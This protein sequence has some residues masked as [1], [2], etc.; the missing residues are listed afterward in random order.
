MF[1]CLRGAQPPPP[2]PFPFPPFA[3]SLRFFDGRTLPGY[4]SSGTRT[5]SSWVFRHRHEA[6]RFLNE[7]WE[8]LEKFGLCL[9]PEKTRLIEFGRLAA[10]RRWE[11]GYGRREF[12]DFLGFTHRWVRKHGK[13]G[14]IVRRTT[15]KKRL[16]AK[17]KEVG[18]TLRKHCHAPLGRQVVWLGWVVRGYFTYYAVPGNHGESGGVPRA[19]GPQL[20]E[21]IARPRSERSDEL[22]TLPTADGVLRSASQI[23]ASLSE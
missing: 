20:A 6:E 11:R 12:F 3:F 14:F 5:T 19:G 22:G 15:V 16:R 8:R 2:P 1:G 18:E 17:L 13:E 9:H 21:G 10:L 23:R 4:V 7:L